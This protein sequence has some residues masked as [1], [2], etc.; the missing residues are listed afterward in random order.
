MRKLILFMAALFLSVASFA[1]NSKAEVLKDGDKCIDFT[2]TDINGKNVSLSDLKGKYVLLDIWATWC[3]PCKKEIP[4]LKKLEKL[5]H[6]KNI[7]FV[8][9]SV[10]KDKKAWEA[11]VK[12]LKLGGIQLHNGGD[13]ALSNA[14]AITGIP[15]FILLDK[16]GYVVKSHMIRPSSEKHIKAFLLG[17][18]GF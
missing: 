1:Q 3:P 2:Y 10:D 9:I 12:D 5:M 4:Y 6:G 15:R 11:M 17:L 16:K 14:F 13:R 8:S 18:K 7:V